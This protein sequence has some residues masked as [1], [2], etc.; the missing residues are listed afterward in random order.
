MF[1]VLNVLWNYT[2]I[3][4]AYSPCKKNKEQNKADYKPDCYIDYFFKK[5]ENIKT[6]ISLLS[7][8]S[9]QLLAP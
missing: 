6:S 5:D 1:I 4:H 3:R 7:F 2:K 8:Y 9:T